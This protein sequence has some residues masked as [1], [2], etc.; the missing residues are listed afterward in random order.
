[1]FSQVTG[2]ILHSLSYTRPPSSPGDWIST[3]SCPLSYPNPWLC[4]T[5][6]PSI[7]CTP[8]A[9]LHTILLPFFSPFPSDIYVHWNKNKKIYKLNLAMGS[10]KIINFTEIPREIVPVSGRVHH[11]CWIVSLHRN[12]M[13]SPVYHSFL[14]P[15]R[16]YLQWCSL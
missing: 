6:C 8:V 9:V 11:D 10:K 14:A 2:L 1:M 7:P 15:P 4:F 5:I 12:W 3:V 13:N 16:Y